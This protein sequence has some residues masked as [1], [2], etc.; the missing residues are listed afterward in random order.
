[1]PVADE[2]IRYAKMAGPR[3]ERCRIRLAGG[4]HI[5][6]ANNLVEPVGTTHCC[7]V[8]GGT[9]A[10]AIG[11]IAPGKMRHNFSHDA[12]VVFAKDF[13][14]L[15]PLADVIVEAPPSDIRSERAA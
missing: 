13:N 2:A 1:M 8:M 4:T 15:R 12:W 7:R 14:L 9:L 10:W 3:F 5:A 6:V 11:T